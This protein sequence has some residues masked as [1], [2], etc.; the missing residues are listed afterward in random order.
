MATSHLGLGAVNY[1]LLFP[2]GTLEKW[3]FAPIIG[4]VDGVG[5]EK[6]EEVSPRSWAGPLVCL[7]PALVLDEVGDHGDLEV[8]ALVREIGPVEGDE[9]EQ[10]GKEPATAS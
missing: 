1:V 6:S 8:L 2:T 10:E 7:N 4:K 9:P 5:K 3:R